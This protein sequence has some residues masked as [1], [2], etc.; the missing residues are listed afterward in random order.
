M[1]ATSFFN[2]S[3]SLLREASLSVR[4]RCCSSNISLVLVCTL[5]RSSVSSISCLQNSCFS[6]SSCCCFFSSAVILSI[7]SMTFVNESSRTRT[8]S[9]N[10][11]QF[12]CALATRAMRC[13]ARSAARSRAAARRSVRWEDSCSRLSVDLENVARAS[14][15]VST[16]R[17]SD[18][19]RSSSLRTARRF[20]YSSSSFLQPS[21]I[22]D[23]NVSSA[24]FAASI[25]SLCSFACAI[26]CRSSA[27]STSFLF[28][29]S[30]AM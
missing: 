27:S 6:Y 20:W 28:L 4:A 24:A 29:V 19:A 11:A 13:I 30:V 9:D 1:S 25:S 12:L 26:A 17:V 16:L 22:C 15:A 18:K 5:I 7:I 21:C 8:A 2:E 23:K 10:I 3:M 14:S